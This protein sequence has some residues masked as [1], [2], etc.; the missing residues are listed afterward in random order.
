MSSK[1]V[2]EQFRAAWPVLVPTIPLYETLNVDPDHSQM[3]ELWCTV[4]FYAP[5][6]YAASIG[7]PSC[8]RESGTIELTL[9]VRSGTTD[10]A[11]NDAAEVIRD[12]FRYWSV[13]ELRVTQI[14]PPVATKGF[15]D[16]MWYVAGVDIAYDYDRFI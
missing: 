3:P 11:M 14:D 6:E 7:Q 16:G 5:N 4:E 9:V 12:A 15:S 13:P 8:R 10:S 1:Y 2:R